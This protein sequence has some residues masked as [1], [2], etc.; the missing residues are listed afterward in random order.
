MESK[1]IVY[2]GTD[3][4]P[5]KDKQLQVHYPI[6][7]SAFQGASQTT[8]IRFYITNI[9]RQDSDIWLVVAKLPNGQV[10]YTRVEVV[11]ENGESYFDFYLTRWHTQYKGDL[12][13]NLQCYSFCLFQ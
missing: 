6:V 2:Y 4:L 13:L 7:G 11:E 10:G 5:Y 3:L 8:C 12:Y 9:V 1:M